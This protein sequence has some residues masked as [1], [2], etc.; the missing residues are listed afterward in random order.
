MPDNEY[1][2]SDEGEA[3]GTLDNLHS[4]HYHNYRDDDE[5]DGDDED[6]GS[7]ENHQVNGH[8]RMSSSSVEDDRMDAITQEE[9]RQI[10]EVLLETRVK[11]EPVEGEN[12]ALLRNG[13]WTS[14]TAMKEEEPNTNGNV[15]LLHMEGE[16][17]LCVLKKKP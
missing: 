15:D 7:D 6:E 12:E 9:E 14:D 17:P 1:Y 2:D 16:K 4:R 11:T 13:N 3:Q 5:G 10:E 8:T